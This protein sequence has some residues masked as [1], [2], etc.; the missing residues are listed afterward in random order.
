[1]LVVEEVD[2]S[3]LFLA[4]SRGDNSIGGSTDGVVGVLGEL[5]PLATIAL[6]FRNL[7]IIYN[8]HVHNIRPT[9][10]HLEP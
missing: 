9:K 5:P 6:L 10:M 8:I 2:L 3:G 4:S 1:M 7:I